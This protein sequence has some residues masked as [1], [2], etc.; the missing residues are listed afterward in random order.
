M[1]YER[2]SHGTCIRWYLFLYTRF[3]GFFLH[4]NK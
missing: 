1:D 2:T 3:L 4:D